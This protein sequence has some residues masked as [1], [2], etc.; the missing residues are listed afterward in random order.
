MRGLWAGVVDA[1]RGM[2]HRA[3]FTLQRG[4]HARERDGNW[5]VQII[6]FKMHEFWGKRGS[7]AVCKVI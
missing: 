6:G 1:A 5:K 4:A 3:G 7:R 2:G